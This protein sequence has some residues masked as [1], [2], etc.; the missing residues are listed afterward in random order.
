MKPALHC[1]LLPLFA[2]LSLLP[3]AAQQFSVK[4]FRQ[5]P[6]DISA[7][8]APVRDLNDEACALIKVVGD[9]DFV[10]S[11]PLGI[12]KQKNEVGEIWVYVPHGTV[13]LTLKHPRWGV[14]RDYRFPRPL[15]SRMTYELIVKPPSTVVW[16]QI[17]PPPAL[18]ARPDALACL[19]QAE[20]DSLPSYPVRL[21]RPRERWHFLLMTNAGVHARPSV[22][23]RA[24]AM[25]RH[26]AYVLL[27]TDFH[28]MPNT[29]GECSR[30]GVPT[31]AS[32]APY[33]TGRTEDARRM[34]LAGAVHR[35][36]GE[37]CLYEGIGYGNRTI[38]WE[39]VD[40]QLLR[41]TGYS[42]KGISAEIGGIYRWPNVALSAGVLTIG[43]EHWEAT[44]GIGWH[45]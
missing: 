30:H 16:E 6:N 21:K 28:P 34:F 27:Q 20:P 12:V 15:E 24:I 5:L 9:K 22:G 40:G 10:F 1:L 14:L 43:A 13:Q 31:G 39:T 32:L 3:A 18:S 37:F 45:F 36:A 29:T 42:V 23:I 25:R 19:P 44:I 4:T 7:Y 35:I 8:I 2:A 26:G 38:G 41:N 33:Y 17:T 11:T